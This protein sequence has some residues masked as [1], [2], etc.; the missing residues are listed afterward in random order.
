MAG[1]LGGGLGG[2]GTSH[3]VPFALERSPGGPTA[4]IHKGISQ[5]REF[6]DPPDMQEKT[7]YL[8]REWVQLYHSPGSGRDSTKA[9]T[10]IVHHVSR[11]QRLQSIN[12][13]FDI[14]D[15]SL[16]RVL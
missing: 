4:H 3:D 15:T 14:Y 7:E 12:H 16:T 11:R 5:A 6:D 9:F 1:S 2:G 8:L 10:I 13:V